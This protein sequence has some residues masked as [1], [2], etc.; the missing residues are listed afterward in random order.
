MANLYNNQP[1]LG[2]NGVGDAVKLHNNQPVAGVYVLGSG[3]VDDAVTAAE[4]AAAI[5]QS[6]ADVSVAAFSE[7]A[8]RLRYSGATGDQINVSAGMYLRDR[9]TG[10]IYQVLASGAAGGDLD[11]TGS[12]GVRLN[13]MP[14]GGTLNVTHFGV[15]GAGGDDTAVFQTAVTAARTR[16]VMVVDVPAGDF[17]I[18]GLSLPSGVWL[19]GAGYERQM[20]GGVRGSRIR[21]TSNGPILTMTGVSV[22]SGGPMHSNARVSG[23]YFS[24]A[25]LSSD[26][27]QMDAVA[28]ANVWQCMF[29]GTSGR[30]IRMREVFDSRFT[31]CRFEYGGSSDGVTAGIDMITDDAGFEAT[32]QIHFTSCVWESFA[33]TA[34]RGMHV[35]TAYNTNEIYFT[36]CKVESVQSSQVLVDFQNCVGV[37]FNMMQLAGRGATG[38]TPAAMLRLQNCNAISGDIHAEVFGSTHADWQSFIQV[39]TSR[40]INMRLSLYGYVMPSMAAAVNHDG[41]NYTSCSIEVLDR[42]IV[43]RGTNIPAILTRDG[44]A[45]IISRTGAEPALQFSRADTAGETWSIGRVVTDGASSAFR[46][47]HNTEEVLRIG[48]DNALRVNRAAAEPSIQFARNDIVGEIW[49]IGRNVA[50]GAGSKFR[51]LHNSTAAIEIYNDNTLFVGGGL[52]VGSAFDSGRLLRMDTWRFWIDAQKRL[53]LFEGF[54]GSDTAGNVIHTNANGATASRPSSPVTGQQFYD[55][56]LSKPIWWSG[57]NWRDA[58]GTIV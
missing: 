57:S 3:L 51:I 11:Y 55:T 34:I 47:V 52:R 28:T 8:S 56:T 58:M 13:V 33:G 2:V 17:I 54:P 38:Q 20:G 14:V 7:L 10:S 29:I 18:N 48:A 5:A 15:V 43:P 25:D 21:R 35:G 36:L 9:S 31:D 41:V 26:M 4:A 24:G 19:R 32:N 37:H 42:V 12:G 49:H 39:L 6:G 45:L 1:V 46:V 27:W 50:D 23:I 40:N 16:G 53:R 22:L 44:D 30:W